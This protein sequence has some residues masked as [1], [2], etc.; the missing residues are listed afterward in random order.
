[1]GA[2]QA[3]ITTG[4]GS[5]GGVRLWRNLVCEKSGTNRPAH[6]PKLWNDI[7][8]ATW[9]DA[10]AE[11]GQYDSGDRFVGGAVWHGRKHARRST[12]VVGA[13]KCAGSRPGRTYAEV[14]VHRAAAI[15]LDVGETNQRG[16]AIDKRL[17]E[18]L[19]GTSCRDV[20]SRIYI[21]GDVLGA[22]VELTFT[23]GLVILVAVPS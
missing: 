9:P 4:F 21:T 22:I 20:L 18:H 10:P 11:V 8:H 12:Q 19:R 7:G 14:L 5:H 16:M 6:E 15:A 2:D 13:N 1:M 17:G 3:A 23:V